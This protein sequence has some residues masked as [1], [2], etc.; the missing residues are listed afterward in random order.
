MYFVDHTVMH[1]CYAKVHSVEHFVLHSAK[2]LVEH[3][4]A[5]IRSD[6]FYFC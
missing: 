4:V 1:I 6:S 5:H 3:S 2:H